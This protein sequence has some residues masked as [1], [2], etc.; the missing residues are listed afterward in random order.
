MLGFQMIQAILSHIRGHLSGFSLPGRGWHCFWRG[1][2]FAPLFDLSCTREG[3][4]NRSLKHSQGQ[5]FLPVLQFLQVS[6]VA[7]I[8]YHHCNSGPSTVNVSSSGSAAEQ[9]SVD[10]VQI[11]YKE[12]IPLP[13]LPPLTAP[14]H[15]NSHS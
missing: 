5:G 13:P 6:S 7:C 1:Q 4:A 9:Y 8:D 14:C 15:L 10:T 3:S 2:G 11:A 12:S